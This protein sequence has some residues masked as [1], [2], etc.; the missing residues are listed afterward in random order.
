M[1]KTWMILLVA[2]G[3][4]SAARPALAWDAFGHEVIARIAWEHMRPETRAK[5]VALLEAAP[6]D[7]DLASLLPRDGRPL[8]ERERELFERAA[9][10]PDIVRDEAFPARH[11]KYHHSTWHYTNFYWELDQNGRPRDVDRLHPED[12]NIV[13]RLHALERSAADPSRDT[14]LRAI[15]LAWLLHLGGDIHQPLHNSARVTA[16]EP[17]GDRGGNLFLLKGDETLHW[18]WDSV[19][20]KT[21]RRHLFE[22]EEERVGRVARAVQQHYPR[23]TFAD[24]LEPGRYEEWSREGFA[25]S[26]SAVYKGVER[27]KEP[28][29]SYRTTAFEIAEPAVAL[30][31]YRL[32]ELLERVLGGA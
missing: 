32:A 3:L 26:K 13:E 31:G 22:S 24:R 4:T 28:S 9:T 16:S 17:E 18:Y 12:V 30:A 29:R 20:S 5:A 10:W 6:P 27:G 11:E 8:A 25:T 7:A 2:V 15:D 21:F 23:S 19:L 1:K 14:S